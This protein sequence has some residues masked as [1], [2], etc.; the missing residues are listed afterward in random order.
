MPKKE[1]DMNPTP[2]QEK[3]DSAATALLSLGS[4]IPPQAEPLV[5]AP[6]RIIV[7][8][9]ATYSMLFF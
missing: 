1:A 8:L 6:R 2:V 5:G 9:S 7:R 4:G 3:D